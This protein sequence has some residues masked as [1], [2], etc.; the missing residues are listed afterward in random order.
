MK[1]SISSRWLHSPESDPDD[2]S[3][4]DLKGGGLFGAFFR[5]LLKNRMLAVLLVGGLAV[6]GSYAYD[7]VPVDAIPDISENQVVVYTPWPGRSPKDVEDQVTY[8]LAVA[9]QGI[10][11]VFDVRSISGFG[12]SQIYVV[13]EDGTDIYWARSR[14]L[15]R[16]NVVQRELPSDAR[17]GLGPDATSLG[18]IFWYTVDS[19]TGAHDLAQLRSIQDWTVKYALQTVKGVAEVASVGGFVQEYQVDADPHRLRAHGVSLGQLAQAVKRANLDVGAKVVEGAGVEYV[20]RGVGFIK[21]LGDLEETVVVA[22]EHVPIRIRDVATVTLGPAFRRGAL[23]DEKGELVGGVVTMR[24]GA[25]PLHV[26]ERVKDALDR[27]RPSLPDGVIIR[28]FYDRTLLVKETEATL[29][30]TL[31]FESLI[32]VIVIL[33]FLLH[34]R[35]SLLV[36]LT[37]PTAVLISFVAMRV[38]GVDANIMSLA[39]IAIAIGTMVDMGIIIT[40]NIHRHL[41]ERPPQVS[42][43]KAIHEATTEVAGAVFT[44]VSTTIVSFLPVFLLTDQEGKLFRPL[45]WTKSFALAS[46]LI[47]SVTLV[48]VLAHYFLKPG[49]VRRPAAALLAGILGGV[50]GAVIFLWADGSTTTPGSMMS[51]ILRVQPV[52]LGALA[53]I[54]VGGLAFKAMRE[55]LTPLEDNPVARGVVAAYTPVLRWVL[56]HKVLFAMAPILIVLWGAMVWLGAGTVLRPATWALEQVG[57]DPDRVRPIAALQDRFPGVGREFMPPLDEGGLLFMPSIL[58]HGSLN[59]SVDVMIAQNK[60]MLEVPEIVRVVGKAGRAETA[61]DPAPVGMIETIL[62]L[63]PRHEWRQGLTL[64]DLIGELRQ[65][66]DIVGVAP[67]WLQPIET[68]IIMLQSGI[69][70]SIGQRIFGPTSE[71]IEEATLVF[72]QALKH[73]QGASDVT[74]LRLMGKPYLEITPSRFRMARYSLRV[75]DVQ[76]IIEVALGGMPQ[77][78]SVEGRE[79]Y[80]IRVRYARA[81]REDIDTIRSTPVPVGEGAYVPLSAVADFKVTAGPAMIRGEGGQLVGYVMF[82][83][84]GRDEVGLVEEA[85]KHLRAMVARGEIEIPDGVYWDWRGRYQNQVRA[86]KRLSVLIPLCLLVNLLLHFLHFGRIGPSLI[87]FLGIPVA[88]AGGFILLDFYGAYL[89]VAVWV[90]FIAVFGIA[91]DDGIVIGTYIQ[92]VIRKRKPTTVAGVRAAVLEAGRKR[93]RPALM[94]SVTTILALVPIFLTAGRGSDVMRPMAVPSIGGMIVAAITWFVVPMAYSA[95]E[96]RRILRMSPRIADD[97]E[98][99]SPGT[100]DIES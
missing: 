30:E 79:R 100:Q 92:Q 25:N 39:G 8:P 38:F 87:V 7:D 59:Q 23:A 32:T 83:A 77:S 94:T 80:P 29:V 10:P 88:L 33:L 81:W 22:R 47:V 70:A 64:A 12:F 31:Q 14:V 36:A 18:Q 60:G 27:L 6:Y 35:S 62:V 74:A 66:T 89:T 19:P 40:E 4:S 98:A 86:A 82:N 99:S 58:P 93:I 75:E 28:P 55:P 2:P 34:I 84:E 63:K 72:E 69:K 11:D 15:E 73:V 96:E 57:I 68:R 65:K 16:L 9:L 5:G 21:K 97:D 17:S 44:A 3:G 1:R 49:R 20:I 52:L 42:R 56:R 46:A 51:G 54:I 50:A 67:S 41:T 71:A 76:R 85:D 48:P 37:L 90:G 53:G 13:F 26:I 95:I 91:A 43:R 61:L 24:Y 78:R 45:A